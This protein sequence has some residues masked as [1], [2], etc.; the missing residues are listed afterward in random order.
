ME[1][2]PVGGPPLLR[3]VLAH[4]RDDD[5]VGQAQ[6]PEIERREQTAHGKGHQ[7]RGGAT[8]RPLPVGINAANGTLSGVPAGSVT[9]IC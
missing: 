6:R 1:G 9:A 8:I 7:G 3:G 4:R 5:A 2:M